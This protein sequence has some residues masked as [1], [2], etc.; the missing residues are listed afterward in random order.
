MIR[1]SA[2][3]VKTFQSCNRQF[4]FKYFDRLPTGMSGRA[5]LGRAVHK[6]IELGFQGQEPFQVFNEYWRAG[7]PDVTSND[8]MQK[9]YNE[10]LKMLDLYDFN[11]IPPLEMELGFELPFPSRDDPIVLM[12]GYFDQILQGDIVVDL[13]TALRRPKIGVLRYSAQFVIYYWAYK[14]LYGVYPKIYWHHLR[15][16]EK[17]QVDVAEDQIEALVP[18]ARG[19]KAQLE[20]TDDIEHYVRNPGSECDYCAYRAICLGRE[21]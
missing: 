18:V 6:A 4:F 15:T 11:Q 21:D 20:Y 10:G 8:N 14:Q 13:K 5:L 12:Q 3:K 9:L 17:F 16:G 1:L 19:L 7:L 2:T